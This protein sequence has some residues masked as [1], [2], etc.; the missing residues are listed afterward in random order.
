MIQTFTS[1]SSW[2]Q[3][4]LIVV[5]GLLVLAI[6][7]A[8]MRW[9]GSRAKGRPDRIPVAPYFVSV[10]TIYAL[11]L[12]FHASTIW[13][14]QHAAE[15]SFEE[16]VTAI[17]RLESLFG[18][19][20]LGLEQARLHLADYVDAVVRDECANCNSKASERANQALASLRQDLI[21]TS[22]QVPTAMGNHLWRVFDDIVEARNGQLWIGSQR[23]SETSWGLVL[24]LGL[25]AHIAIGW[26]HA[27]RPAAGTLAM[28]LFALT[29]SAAYWHVTQAAD[30][31]AHLDATHYLQALRGQ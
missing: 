29:T 28:M 20:G 9:L 6:S 17:A 30:P 18:K 16:A 15:A 21:Q 2:I 23:R 7:W 31:F 24:A 5:H 8:S 25:L 22:E 26:V 4:L 11:F 1:L 3:I 10:T 27:D 14:R 12:A 19:E 13:S